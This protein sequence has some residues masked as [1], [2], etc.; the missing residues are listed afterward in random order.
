MQKAKGE[1]DNY[2]GTDVVNAYGFAYA[3]RYEEIEKRYENSQEQWFD[4]DGTPLTKEKEMEYLNTAYEAAAA[5]QVSSAKVMAGLRQMPEVS[6]KDMEGLENIFY[7][8]RDK[9]TELCKESM[10][11]GEPMTFQR[12]SFGKSALLA[13]LV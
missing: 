4:I 12:L 1:K 2:D 6:Q 10:I 8:S 11:T 9:Y 3:R 5:F 13:L 7:R